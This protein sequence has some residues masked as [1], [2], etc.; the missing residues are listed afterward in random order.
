L[1]GFNR[2]DSAR[3]AF[4]ISLPIIFG[5]AVWEGAHLLHRGLSPEMALSFGAGLVTSAVSG[6]LA[7]RFLIAY[8][9]RHTLYLFVF[10]RLIVGAACLAALWWGLR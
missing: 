3:Y 5:A 6:Y 1:L 9:A 10:Y 8:L 2:S 7:V 4:L